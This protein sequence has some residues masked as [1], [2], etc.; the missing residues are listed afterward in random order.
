MDPVDRRWLHDKYER[1]AAEEGQLAA[2]RTS[3]FAAIGTVLI[4]G[5]VVSLTYFLPQP[6]LLAATTTFLAGIGILISIVWA[7]LLHRTL[8]A[9]AMWREGAQALERAQPPIEGELPGKITLRSGATIEVDLLRPY[10]AHARRFSDDTAVSWMDRV[11]PG[12]LTEILPLS[13]LV[14]WCAVL[15]AIWIY[16]F[17]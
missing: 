9:Q 6:R 11:R 16:A 17:L 13:F 2:S 5:F 8:D 1:L 3:Y 4:T 12:T 15:S 7:V 10:L 14:I